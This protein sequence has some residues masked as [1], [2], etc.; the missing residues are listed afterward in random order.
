[1]EAATMQRVK[2]KAKLATPEN[3]A[4]FGQIL[5]PNPN[6]TPLPIDFYAGKAKVSR[7]VDFKSDEQTELTLVTLDRRS[8]EVRWME[9]HFKHTQTFIPLA[10][11]PFIAVMAPPTDHDLPDLDKVEAFLFDGTAGFTMNLGTWHEFPFSILDGTNLIVI[12]RREAT[13]S[14]KKENVVDGEAF[15]PDLDKKDIST[16]K[17]IT[18][19]VEL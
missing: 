19:E 3:T 10:G 15:G 16:R 1:M 6:I 7:V 2:L 13:E 4:A 5:G 17:H 14:L 12:L 11:K 18:F 8:M 9:R